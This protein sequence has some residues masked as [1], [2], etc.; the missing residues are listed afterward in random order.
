MTFMFDAPAR[1]AIKKAPPGT[2]SSRWGLGIQR[3]TPPEGEPFK[4][5]VISDGSTKEPLR[6]MANPIAIKKFIEK[7]ATVNASKSGV[8]SFA[9]P[10]VSRTAC[11]D[12]LDCW[13]NSS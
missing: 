12:L 4:V 6:L 5:G 1:G 11:P 13:L 3:Y 7:Q 10:Q 8:L 9:V 2:R